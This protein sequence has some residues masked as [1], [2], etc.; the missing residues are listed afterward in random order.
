MAECAQ[1]GE[2]KKMVMLNCA[3]RM[4]VYLD[5]LGRQEGDLISNSPSLTRVVRL[6]RGVLYLIGELPFE[7]GSSVDDVNQFRENDDFDYVAFREKQCYLSKL[8]RAAWALS[9][10]E[11]VCWREVTQMVKKL[12][13]AEVEDKD[14]DKDIVNQII[15]RL[16]TWKLQLRDT[17]LPK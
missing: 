7:M 13:E 5:E 11:M 3:R 12:S 9:A 10:G 15:E 16:P 1:A 2:D 8:I 4:M 14:E 17:A 6:V